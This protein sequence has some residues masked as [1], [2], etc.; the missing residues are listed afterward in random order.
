MHNR[1]QQWWKDLDEGFERFF[2]T[3]PVALL[4]LDDALVVREANAAYLSATGRKH[5]Q[6][7]GRYVFDVFPDNPHAPGVNSVATF[8]ASFERV[9]QHGGRDVLPVHRYDIPS[10][11]STTGFVERYWSPLSVPLHDKDKNVTGILHRVEDATAL[12][13]LLETVSTAYEQTE[14]PVRDREAQRLYAEYAAGAERDRARLA[15]M[16]AKVE[17]LQSAL[18]SRAVIDQA[19]GVIIAQR[20]LDPDDAFQVL[21]ELSQRTNTKLRDVATALVHRTTAAPAAPPAPSPAATDT[22]RPGQKAGR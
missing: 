5:R 7:V 19:V 3:A 13:R 20:H 2:R 6:L 9:L 17:Q 1:A 12:H 15:R 22:T 14:T 18:A 10:P 11:R 8:K 21:V 16:E 4:V